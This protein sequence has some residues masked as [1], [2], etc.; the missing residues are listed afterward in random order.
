MTAA[1]HSHLR[2]GT[3]AAELVGRLSEREREVLGYIA[4]GRSTVGIANELVV[5]PHTVRT[6]VRNILRKLETSSRAHAAALLMA[7]THEAAAHGAAVIPAE[8]TSEQLEKHLAMHTL[9]TAIDARDP[10]SSSHSREVVR[11]AGELALELG[12]GPSD[13]VEVMDVATL[14][15]VGK[16]GVPEAILW[17][18]GPLDGAE[19]AIMNR[20]TEIGEAIV[21]K[22][23]PL[24]HLGPA[25]RSA[26]ERWDAG[27]YPDGI[28]A[29]DIPLASRIVFVCDAYDAM[30]TDRSYRLAI[31]AQQ[32]REELRRERGRQFGPTVVDAFFRVLRRTAG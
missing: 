29:A 8:A 22:I 20:H 9:L 4:E 13:R 11:L 24:A 2:P 26:H 31:T 3:P 21:A 25:I 5:S 27:G 7:R 1:V 19:R 14:H 30:T 32:A 15:D 12:L 10:Y 28:A 6:H 18:T 16:L 17:K 23:G